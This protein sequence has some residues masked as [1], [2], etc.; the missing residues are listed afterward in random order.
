MSRLNLPSFSDGYDRESVAGDSS[1]PDDGP[2]PFRDIAPAVEFACW[3]VVALAPFLRWVNGAAVTEDQFIIQV[4]VTTLALVGALS[5]R[6]YNY[7]IKRR[8]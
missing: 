8:A 4:G 3:V 5:L 7:R 2:I 6:F 1:E